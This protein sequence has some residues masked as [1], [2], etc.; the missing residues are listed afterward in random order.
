M[1]ECSIEALTES[2]LM[3]V[4]V[5]NSLDLEIARQNIGQCHR[6]LAAGHYVVAPGL[7]CLL[8][9]RGQDVRTEGDDSRTVCLWQRAYQIGHIQPRRCQ[10]QD[11]TATL[12]CG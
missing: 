8:Q 5:P 2:S 4:S 9:S 12:Q 3:L 7:A 10:V 1:S 6:K 11:E